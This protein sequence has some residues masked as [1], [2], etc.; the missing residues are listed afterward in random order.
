M[1]QWVRVLSLRDYNTRVVLL[2]TMLLGTVAGVVG[3][4]MLLRKRALVGD[5]VGH[6]CLPGIAIAFIVMETQRAGSGKW[7][8]GLLV[9][10][11]IAG[12]LGLASVTAIGRISRIKPD[13]A[14]A[15]VLSVFFGLGVALLTVVQNMPTGT[16]AG[17]Q[18]FVFGKAASMVAGDVWLIA[19]VSIGVLVLC[20][21]AFKELAMLVCFDEG[22]AS[23][24]G[25]P[26][27]ALDLLLMGLVA[28]VA[29]IGLQS[30]GLLLVVAL[31]IIPAAAARFW[32]DRLLLMTLAAAVLGGLSCAA[33]VLVSAMQ[34]RLAAGAVIVLMAA[35]VF[36]VSLLVG[37][38]RGA[39]R[40]MWEARRVRQRV[41]RQH[42]LRSFY[43][44]LEAAAALP[45]EA[46]GTHPRT[47]AAD[48]AARDVS[49]EELLARRPWSEAH[50]DRLLAAAA[51]DGL[52]RSTVPGR[53]ALTFLG[54][55]RARR[56]A[57]DHR[58]WE[59]YLIRY[60]DV[61]ASRVDRQ[62]D[63]IEHVLDAETIRS[64]EEELALREPPRLDVPPS[65]HALEQ[66]V[67]V[68][69]TTRSAATSAAG[70]ATGATTGSAATSAAGSATGA[71]TVVTT[72]PAAGSAGEARSGATG[73]PP[74]DG[75]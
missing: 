14:L 4:L 37:T 38:R 70:S 19:L 28:V 10:A 57:R 64:L 53:F 29:V 69:S 20:A 43:E 54:A 65:P 8:P 6:A 13:A 7:L 15:I 17:L 31:L 30:V 61:A 73:S 46:A 55:E 66:P 41:G 9:G 34:P 47:A 33:G 63:E 58:L 26:V 36:A 60:A 51:R 45:G 40:R 75:G 3:T 42:L 21:L 18:D 5:V 68:E 56:A 27:L 62:A 59:L 16:A 49:R 72:E 2:G 23:A 39:L 1:A 32:T 12:L 35:S 71:T 24:Q 74:Q 22:Y 25:W 11:L 48:V 50:V 44:A 67:G 52:V